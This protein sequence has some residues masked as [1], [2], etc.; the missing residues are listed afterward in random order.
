MTLNEFNK[1]KIIDLTKLDD[2]DDN[3]KKFEESLTSLNT[4]TKN[5]L[6]SNYILHINSLYEKRGLTDKFNLVELNP[7][8][9]E[10]IL[11]NIID[12]NIKDLIIEE[13][14][15]S[16]N[17]ITKIKAYE[18]N[19]FPLFIDLESLS[20]WSVEWTTRYPTLNIYIMP[21]KYTR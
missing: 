14:I 7:A 16:S 4:I 8:Q 18:G 12:D 13:Q 2:I 17:K 9:Y 20:I 10:I 15:D 6:I 11:E 3:L 19:H 5:A 21:S 1:D